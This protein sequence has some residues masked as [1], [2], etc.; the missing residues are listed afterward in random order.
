MLIRS[1]KSVVTHNNT[2]KESESWFDFS[3][4]PMN[5]R[6]RILKNFWF[7]LRIK[8]MIG[9]RN[10]ILHKSN[11]SSL[12]LALTMNLSLMQKFKKKTIG[13]NLWAVLV[14]S[15]KMNEYSTISHFAKEERRSVKW[16]AKNKK[17]KDELVME[18][19]TTKVLQLDFLSKLFNL[20]TARLTDTQ[21]TLSSKGKL[22]FR[23]STNYLTKALKKLLT[24]LVNS[25]DT[26]TSS[27]KKCHLTP[28]QK[29]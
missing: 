6:A 9:L 13:S 12:T 29:K 20:M 3:L 24:N 1:S 18:F 15:Q 27:L 26:W 7:R 22:L 23:R 11:L 4:K 28:W 8:I 10:W 21:I 2:L 16:S 14:R 25:K 19:N 17:I 5:L